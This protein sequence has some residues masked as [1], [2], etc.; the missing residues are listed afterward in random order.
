MI[1]KN[2][3]LLRA[4]PEKIE[5]IVHSTSYHVNNILTIFISCAINLL[6]NLQKPE[7]NR[8]FLLASLQIWDLRDF[9]YS[10][11]C[12]IAFFFYITEGK[13]KKKM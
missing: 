6:K 13:K 1:P 7:A 5:S 11:F 4:Q 3:F 12:E 8:L 2:V 9:T 10:I